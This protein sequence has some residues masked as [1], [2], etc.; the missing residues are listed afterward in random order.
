MMY[1]VNVTRDGRWWMIEVPEL[2][3]LTQA[4]R[5][6][7]ITDQAVSLIS[8]WLDVAPSEVE[9]RIAGLP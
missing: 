2:D 3:L 1:D 6:D 8:A 9:V 7:E 5:V 4:R